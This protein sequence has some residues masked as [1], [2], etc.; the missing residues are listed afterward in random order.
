M[1]GHSHSSTTDSTTDCS[2][3]KPHSHDD[4]APIEI[5][6]VEPS[7][8]VAE[9]LA[10]FA[11]RTSDR[12]VVRSVDRVA[13][14]LAAAD[15]ADCVVTEQR[16]PDGTG[17][18]LL[19]DLRRGGSDRPIVFHT[20]CRGAAVEAEASAAGADAYVRK[21]ASRGQYDA[22]LDR[23][24]SLVREDRISERTAAPAT[25]PVVSRRA[26]D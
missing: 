2:T 11:D 19:D 20:T 14:A 26:E 24:R 8:R 12:F 10:A 17:I 1:T 9:L 4:S 13:T 6:H 5:L 18:E 15:G 16:L 21:T 23:V 3:L 7:S 22:I 25:D